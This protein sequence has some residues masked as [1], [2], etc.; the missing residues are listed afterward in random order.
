L[1]VLRA[2]TLTAPLVALAVSTLLVGGLSAPAAA[3]PPAK[4]GLVSMAFATPTIDT[5]SGAASVNL[6]WTVADRA[7]DSEQV[8]GSVSVR[9]FVGNAPVGPDFTITFAR[10][11]DGAALVT[12]TDGDAVNSTYAYPF[13]VGQYAPATS[14]TWRVVGFDATGGS[15]GH[16]SLTG[17]TME[18]YDADL[19]VTALAD[20]TG[21]SLDFMW[22]SSGY[23]EIAYDQG[24]GAKLSYLMYISDAESG[25]WKG[26]FT[27]VGPGGASVT[28]PFAVT[29]DY[30]QRMCG[31]DPVWSDTTFV[32]CDIEVN[33][34]VGAPTG[35]WR[36][37]GTTLTDLAGNSTTVTDTGA[38]SVLVARDDVVT[39]SGFTI[40][41][42]VVENWRQDQAVTLSFA[43][44]GVH[45]G[46][47]D[48]ETDAGPC[49]QQG[50]VPQAH[51][52]GTYS[53]D[54][55]M[56]SATR[57]CRITGVKLTDGDGNFAVY[58]SDYA[59]AP[60]LGDL[61]V[62]TVSDTTPPMV[63]AASL[64]TTTISAAN[65]PDRIGVDV[66]VDDSGG[67]P[68][69][70]GV[71]SVYDA[72]GNWVGGSSG[73]GD[74]VNGVMHLE[75]GVHNLRPGTYT[76]SFMIEDA[77][78]NFA[79]YGGPPPGIPMPGGPLILTVT[80]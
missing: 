56:T 32:I 44:D 26:S 62:N 52:D 19:G 6:T 69:N 51:A 25:F 11:P 57:Q 29:G 74:V 17:K 36:I 67:A 71:V 9:E 28:Q 77:A 34:P 39:A 49:R 27:V 79:S 72:T 12:A 63:T 5:T 42:T 41:P 15:G 13:P 10:H 43:A 50:T 47:V 70:T 80:P 66:S 58:G 31:T 2:R 48:I 24:G 38:P 3:A 7:N 22:I 33:L 68:I 23:T 76:I 8:T 21:P 45:G 37:A 59:G 55:L 16:Q 73:G 54:Y 1:S 60:G 64:S 35:Q 75:V 14:S 4:V 53:I 40:T 78:G 30:G 46:I 18:K 65:L 20:T 61:V